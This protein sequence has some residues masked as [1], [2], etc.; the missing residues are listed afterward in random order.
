M[1]ERKSQDLISLLSKSPGRG[2][3][4]CF[5]FLLFMELCFSTTVYIFLPLYLLCLLFLFVN[6]IAC[7]WQISEAEIGTWFTLTLWNSESLGVELGLT[8]RG[9]S[10]LNVSR[11]KPGDPLVTPFPQHT[12]QIPAF[13]REPNAEQCASLCSVGAYTRVA[14]CFLHHHPPRRKKIEFKFSLMRKIK[15]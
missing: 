5:C 7:P 10:W 8:C 14:Q 13:G 11:N 9:Q 1:E 12:T 15:Y 2:S 6:K 3:R 4:E